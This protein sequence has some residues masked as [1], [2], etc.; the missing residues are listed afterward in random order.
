[1]SECTFEIATVSHRFTTHEEAGCLSVGIGSVFCEE[2][3]AVALEIDHRSTKHYGTIVGRRPKSGE[4]VSS[5]KCSEEVFPGELEAAFATSRA[6]R[7]R[8]R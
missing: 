8:T 4:P 7:S 3:N 1:M 2:T 5:E 6:T